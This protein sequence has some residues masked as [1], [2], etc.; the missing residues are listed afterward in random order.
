MIR[1]VLIGAGLALALVVGLPSVAIA[2]PTPTTTTTI[3]D[4]NPLIGTSTT[5]GIDFTN[6]GASG[7]TGFGP[8]LDVYL[9]T[10]GADGDDGLTLTGAPD[11]HGFALPYTTISCTG[12]AVTHP[13]TKLSVV[14]PAGTQLVVVTV[15]F[16]SFSAG[17]PAAHVTLP[18]SVSNL[19][20]LG[21]ALPVSVTGGFRFG[22]DPLDNPSTDAPITG[23]TSSASATPALWH[24]RK[25]YVGPECETATGP[26]FPRSYKLDIDIAPGQTV[27]ALQ[28][29]DALP[30]QVA[31]TGTSAISAGG[32]VTT[33]PALGVVVTPG[34]RTVNVAWAGG[35]TGTASAVDATATIGFFVPM[36]DAGSGEILPGGADSVIANS[37][38]SNGLWTPIDPRDGTS[39][40]T[41]AA[42]TDAGS[43]S[44]CPNGA[45]ET[46]IDAEALA[47]QK[48]AAITTDT[49]GAGPTPGDTVTFTIQGQVSDY[50]ALG[51]L[52]VDDVM[53]DGLRR[54]GAEPKLAINGV[55]F[56]SA[57]AD[58]A[59]ANYT[60]AVDGAAPGSARWRFDLSSELALRVPSTA[61]RV[62]GGCVPTGGTADPAPCAPN[63][64]PTTFT[65]TYQATI[66]QTYD[67]QYTTGSALCGST[68]AAPGGTGAVNA[69]D[70]L[71]NGATTTADLLDQST[72]AD[73]GNDTADDTGASVTIVRNAMTKSLYAING[74]TGLPTGNQ[75]QPGDTVTYRITYAMPT[76]NVEQFS[77]QDFLPQP[78]YD[79]AG[80][81]VLAFDAPSASP[82]APGHFQ[83]NS[84]DTY[85]TYIGGSVPA[86][87]IT[88]D[89][90]SNSVVYHFG[91]PNANPTHAA[92][93]D[94][95]YT[96]TVTNEPF[97]DE[98][99][100]TNQVTALANN[101]VQATGRDDA[102]ARVILREPDVQVTKGVAATS[103]ASA[104]F[105]PAPPLPAGAAV[106]TPGI[107]PSVSGITA[108]NST[109]ID[110][111]VTNLDAGDIVRYAVTYRNEGGAPAR[112]LRICDTLPVSPTIFDPGVTNFTV[113]YGNGDPVAMTGGSTEFFDC[114]TAPKGVLVTSLVPGAQQLTAYT[115][116]HD[117]V[118]VTYDRT[119][120]AT[121]QDAYVDVT[122][123]G[124]LN[125]FT[126]STGSSG[127]ID[128]GSERTDDAKARSAVNPTITKAITASSAASTT[129]DS[130]PTIGERLTYT[131][132]MTLREGTLTNAVFEDT[133]AN[134][135]EFA[136]P[137]LQSIT[138]DAGVTMT[139][140][141][142]GS[143]TYPTARTMRLSLGDVTNMVATGTRKITLVYDVV[144]RDIT[145]TPNNVQGATRANAAKLTH[146]D[147][148]TPAVGLVPAC[149]TATTTATLQE[150]APTITKGV[151]ST[152]AGAPGAN[153]DLDAGDAAWWTI[154]AANTTG[155]PTAYDAVVTDTIPTGLT[156][157]AGTLTINGPGV[158]NATCPTGAPDTLTPFTGGDCQWQTASTIRVRFDTILAGAANAYT[159]KY[160][161]DV[162]TLTAQTGVVMTNDADLTAYSLPSTHT[163][164]SCQHALTDCHRRSYTPSAS[165]TATIRMAKPTKTLYSTSAPNAITSG[166]DV[167][168][169]ERAVYEVTA[170]IPEGTT[171]DL[172]V[173]DTVDA[174][175]VFTQTPVSIT[176][177]NFAN[178]TSP[179]SPSAVLPTFTNSGRTMT[180]DFGDFVNNDSDADVEQ[181]VIR[182]EVQVT[183]VAG[184]QAGTS[185]GNDASVTF[186]PPLGGT[187][188]LTP[189][190]PPAD[191][192]V[193]EPSVTV[194]KTLSRVDV[195]GQSYVKVVVVASN[196]SA[197]NTTAAFDLTLRD[198][199]TG[200]GLT[201]VSTP[202]AVAP[203]CSFSGAAHTCTP[204]F[205]SP[206]AGADVDQ[207]DPGQ[208]V[209][210][211]FYTQLATGY[212]VG[213]SIDNEAR[214]EWTSLPVAQ[215][216]SGN[217]E[218]TV[219]AADCTERTGTGTG[220]NDYWDEDDESLASLTP[221]MTK[222]LVSTNQAHTSGQDVAIG[223]TATY[224]V[225][226]TVPEGV[227]ND[228][229]VTDTLDD[230][231]V[232]TTTAVS[233]TGSGFTTPPI[234]SFGAATTAF[235]NNG[236]TATITLGDV[237]N[238]D[239]DPGAET[240]TIEYVVL[241]ANASGNDAGDSLGNDASAT[242]LPDGGATTT[243]TP[244]SLPDDLVVR[245]PAVDVEKTMSRVTVS[246]SPYVKVV[247][248]A[249]NT[250]SFAA[251]DATLRDDLSG[252][253]LT[254]V[255][256]PPVAPT[257]TFDG[258]AHTC[259]PGVTG[260]IATADIDR[261]DAGQTVTWTFYA[262]EDSTSVAGVQVT[263]SVRGEWTSVPGGI[264]VT[265]VAGT[266]IGV[267]SERTGTQTPAHNDYTDSDSDTLAALE[268]SITKSI[269]D[270]SLAST[271]QH[272]SPTVG[273][274]IRYAA[275]VTVPAGTTRDLGVRDTLDA[276]LAFAADAVPTEVEIVASWATG[277]PPSAATNPTFSTTGG[278]LHRMTLQFGDVVNDTGAPQTVTIRYWAV[279]R[280]AAG[281][282]RG[283]TA[284]NT[285][286]LYRNAN[287]TGGSAT[288]VP[289]AGGTAHA[290]N[291]TVVEPTLDIAKTITPAL[292]D[293]GQPATV[294]LVVQ[295]TGA[296]N[297]TAYGIAVNDPLP[298][299]MTRSGAITCAPVTVTCDSTASTPTH[300]NVLIS[301]LTTAQTVTITIP[302]TMSATLTPGAT[303]SN[304]GYVDWR[305][306]PDL[307]GYDVPCAAGF[308]DCTTRTGSYLA[309]LD[310]IDDYTDSSTA[311][312]T[313][314]TV[315]RLSGHVWHDL[316]NDGVRDVGESMIQG[317]TIALTG[318][319]LLGNPVTATTTTDAS[320]FYEFDGLRPG[321]YQIT[322]TQPTGWLDGKDSL[323]DIELDGGGAASGNR[324]TAGN[325]QFSSIQLAIGESTVGTNYDF[326]ELRPS[327]IAGSVWGE[328]D[329]GPED[330][331][332]NGTD[333]HL[334]GVTITLTGTDD[335]GHAVTATTTTD[336]SGNYSF[337]N[338][339]P[340]TYTV[341][342]TQPADW[343]TGGAILGTGATGAG[344]VVNTNQMSTIVLHE[345]QNGVDY[346][347]W[348]IVRVDV[349]IDKQ[350]V[351]APANGIVGLNTDFVWR[352]RVTNNGPSAAT[353][354]VF[355]DDMAPL[356]EQNLTVTGVA[357]QPGMTCG[358]WTDVAAPNLTCSIASL[359]RGA[360]TY[361]DL[362]MHVDGKPATTPED[363]V[364]DVAITGVDQVDTDPTN[365]TDTDSTK[366]RGGD[367]GV[368][369]TSNVTSANVGDQVTWTLTVTNHGPGTDPAVTLTDTMPARSVLVS[370]SPSKG[371]CTANGVS[372]AT[373]DCTIGQMVSG[374]VVTIT[375][376][377]MVPEAGTYRN[378]TVVHPGGID[379]NPDNNSSE[380][381]VV[382][383]VP[384]LGECTIEGDGNLSGTGGSDVI[385]GGG[386]PD[387]ID[388][389]TGGNTTVIGGG[390]DDVITCG[391]DC[392]GVNTILGGA[393]N[394]IIHVQCPDTIVDGGTGN[395]T[396]IVDPGV[397]GHNTLCGG[398]GNDVI[399][400]G[401]GADL[402]DGG[403]G[404][405][406]VYG[407]NG[408]DRVYGGTGNDLVDGGAGND[409]LY[410]GAGNDRI[411]GWA[412]FDMLFG[413]NG[414]DLLD[415]GKGPD[416][417]HGGNGNDQ[418]KFR[419]GAPDQVIG[420]RG[421]DTLWRD[422]Y[423]DRWTSVETLR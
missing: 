395:D 175:M 301:Q 353:N 295:H 21:H 168:I 351:P 39:V 126:T 146:D 148:S 382:V 396:I 304:T 331:V 208:T 362:T 65:I 169:G 166:N 318:T 207:L 232:F 365:D 16:G 149:P 216:P 213:A 266:P 417:A 201:Y 119:V 206:V 81:S 215:Q 366:V 118:V 147:C 337:T 233:I 245:E 373:I 96:F 48:S 26:N 239:R 321:T 191:L 332:F 336:A 327:S 36:R 289:G 164:P 54:T 150:P 167:V 390:G 283:T 62:L 217:C 27:N 203:T 24:L 90:D 401:T 82:P 367:V 371:A 71:C 10:A 423:L 87:T 346:D 139:A 306:Q 249:K 159:I 176:K 342:Q 293:A 74:D 32:S 279:V 127:F 19:A 53:S 357:P 296:S 44:T 195:G 58:I 120:K 185:I 242:Y 138:T 72:F 287:E 418:L 9:D 113:T 260:A 302:V 369:K 234:P 172:K 77:M 238:R 222:S 299:D 40:S 117:V 162:D 230:G 171:K 109:A 375:V 177:V 128:T 155:R 12:A 343:A 43:G 356:G 345:D 309:P 174:G 161:T 7:E 41:S 145:G 399:R 214:G 252:H 386:G 143:E 261:I 319:D 136:S 218:A 73:T 15:P 328:E 339:R 18:V 122:N 251:F 60:Y 221:S 363:L 223:E 196:S 151:A 391:G 253:H 225:V 22:A 414:A 333:Q 280:N 121:A 240:I 184:N 45:R 341:T 188:T 52:V 104:V 68:V 334:Q 131:V 205:S 202:A 4:A 394:D 99:L 165:A 259:T 276:G 61:G 76:I 49:G 410:G 263:N 125:Q 79:V 111:N 338:L 2:A 33:Q 38:D 305:S 358:A 393:G 405:D 160:R 377:A 329:G 66:Q 37:A 98:L 267:C 64:G 294:T 325:D 320:G 156:Y 408:N 237:D 370:T 142:L 17:Q 209:T 416:R 34:N 383:T 308:T 310:P 387:I 135:L 42:S 46:Q 326:G 406:K 292:V 229:E 411:F 281:V 392:D 269:V 108:T 6:T 264:G 83:W 291:V 186:T 93:I 290:G 235:T 314:A 272:S 133:L 284:S 140:G 347:F 258:T 388:C 313:G 368:V 112:N 355:T 88:T 231:L 141:T 35:V 324:G 51:N 248:T 273:E 69:G 86:P 101:T 100:L 359:A 116:G 403:P 11:F 91:S 63:D 360:S 173:I 114:A 352:V 378:A 312:T 379:E 298:T 275:V 376:V 47:I 92:T 67:T 163:T 170:T 204:G 137:G 189:L 198:D 106:G 268:P 316:D 257:C 255:S 384:G 340:G 419:D 192:V 50:Y 220:P 20:D 211:T 247:V 415:G 421:R 286:E 335:L 31:Y 226:V 397:G 372:G 3:A 282:V 344:A 398:P 381:T 210:W 8:Y 285:A 110:S 105:S 123:T 89:A 244:P 413:E 181:L 107:P 194:G 374:E 402:I 84:T 288:L 158:V 409:K 28:L 183:N 212:Q 422:K 349:A 124:Q 364:N 199:L 154:T 307:P 246:G 311:V 80:E 59:G 274:R 330:G 129:P 270:S 271:T 14:C 5:I 180:L 315:S 187:T 56:T 97:A 354:V 55:G 227:T 115:P 179:A 224:R 13:L 30:L 412:G 153:V 193:R 157:G 407:K 85:H 236:R 317:V 348:E 243:F 190:T 102:F 380:H 254:Y 256:A 323:G 303:V 75:V 29:D 134:G 23:A 25:T 277:T 250:S 95:L 200:T 132:T 197:A 297:A 389:G 350:I 144:V 262:T 1:R 94:I 103:S 361:V 420:G 130:S 70:T 228:L 400:G 78:I 219:P 152:Q 322:Q 57:A 178:A 265:C 278:G 241:V 385:C 300:A 182:Y 404:A